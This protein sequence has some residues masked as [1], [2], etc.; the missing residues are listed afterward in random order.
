MSSNF[1]LSQV[2]NGFS[3]GACTKTLRQHSDYVICLAAAEKNVI[4]ACAFSVGLLISCHFC[5]YSFLCLCI[6][7]Q[8][9]RVWWPWG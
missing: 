6:A 8:H 9:C 2:W 5:F 4:H 3:E 7:E 1:Y